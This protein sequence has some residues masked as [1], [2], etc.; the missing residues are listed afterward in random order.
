MKQGTKQRI[1]GSVVLLSL[2]LIFL[3][4]LFDGEGSYQAPVS[5]RIPEPPAIEAMPEANPRRPVILSDS[6]AIN[7][8]ASEPEASAETSP[9]PNDAVAAEPS[10]AAEAV[11]A[12]AQAEETAA[13]DAEPA[14]LVS[15]TTFDATGLPEGWSVRLGS[16]SDASNAANLLQRLQDD[17][18]KAYSRI[19]QNNQRQLTVVYVGPWLERDRAD[20]YLSELQDRFQLSGMVERY[21]MQGL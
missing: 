12:Q 19:S 2:A 3:P 18:Y 7:V 21:E 9:A 17:G 20:S 15:D 4:I 8:A 13:A 1:V 14:G 11:A 6:D 16:F 5:S 10:P